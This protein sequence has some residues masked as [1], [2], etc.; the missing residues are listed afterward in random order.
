MSGAAR[1]AAAAARRVGAGLVKV[2]AP[3][4]ARATYMSDAAGLMFVAATEN[5]ELPDQRTSAVLIG[6]G[7]GVGADTRQKVLEL[8]K[9]DRATVLDADALTSFADDPESLFSA[10]KSCQAEVVLTP[11]SGEF[12]TLF[13]PTEGPDKLKVTQAAAI[14]SGA[15]VVFKGSDTVIAAPEG[16]AAISV[17]APPWLAT[18][19]SGDVLAGLVC[20]LLAQGMLG[21]QAAC[22]G[23]WLHGEAAEMVG[24]GLIAE[25]LVDAIPEIL[26]KA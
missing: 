18:A 19:G 16:M 1:L 2:C 14:A 21:W 6:P 5:I 24:R 17:N 25:D 7:F 15:V 26:G 10:I 3:E 12:S 4:I 11:H 22:A 20:G 23:V 9:S 8:L 13:G